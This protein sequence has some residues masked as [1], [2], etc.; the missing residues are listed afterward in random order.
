[1]SVLWQDGFDAYGLPGA[2]NPTLG[3][4]IDAK[5][6]SNNY[7]LIQT[8]TAEPDAMVFADT[9]DGIGY[10]CCVQTSSSYTGGFAHTLGAQTGVIVGFR[11]K[12]TND[13]PQYIFT[14]GHRDISGNNNP[15]ITLSIEADHS[16]KAVTGDN[17]NT[18]QSSSN[19]VTFN[20]WQRIEI[21]Y[22]IGE[23]PQLLQVKIDGNTILHIVANPTTT[24]TASDD[25]SVSLTSVGSFVSA[26]S[27]LITGYI[28]NY[29]G[30]TSGTVVTN[31]ASSTALQNATQVN[32]I[33]YV[34]FVND[35]RFSL[36]VDDFYVFSMD[37]NYPS[38]FIGDAVV[39]TFLPS[40]DVAS[41]PFRQFGG[42]LL[43]K[44]TSVN[45]VEYAGDTSCLASNNP[46]D[47]ALFTPN[48]LPTGII[49]IFNVNVTNVSRAGSGTE[50]Y[51]LVLS[52]GTNT[53]T[54]LTAAAS[55]SYAYYTYNFPKTPGGNYWGYSDL[56]TLEFGVKVVT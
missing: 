9:Q 25:S 46:G 47:L 23:D 11:F 14:F 33:N 12:F 53:E 34:E 44:F 50:N 22:Q 38:D 13:T 21:K 54:S 1:M 5:L 3:D 41:E 24:Y 10:S 18:Y 16:I 39:R 8:Y 28:S 26:I 45:G 27:Y 7:F 56:E 35:A 19:V 6:V 52:D 42:N 51:Q 15:Q 36:L 48:N 4:I 55:T 37:G 32:K 20:V 30:G 2:T 17:A 49:D 40:A 43:G 31:T 29:S